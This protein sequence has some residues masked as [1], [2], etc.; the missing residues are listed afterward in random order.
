MNKLNKLY[1]AMLKSWGCTFNEDSSVQLNL[2]GVST[3]VSVDSKP[4]YLATSEN[5]N[6]ITIGKVFFH[7]AC[8]SIMSKETEIFKVI[9]KL[10]MAKIFSVF[11]P[12]CEVLF[13]IA[14][15][16]TGK[17]IPGKLLEQLEPFKGVNKNVRQE[18]ID[19]IK[20]VSIVMEDQG[21]DTRL[22]NFTL[23]KGGKNENDEPV[24][25]T[26]TPSFP[27]YTEL[28]RTAAQNEHLKPT[29]RLNFNNLNVSIQA[30]R[31]VI[32]LFEL[33]FPA[34]MDPS[35]CKY[36]VTT[37]DAA[38]LVAYLRSYGLIAADIN[39]LIGK[40]RK[41][42]DSIGLYGID[43]EWLNELDEIGE[44]KKLI[45]ALDYN[46]YNTSSST[47]E[48]RATAPIGARISS[49]N[50]L[51][52]LMGNNSGVSNGSANTAVS[53]P[54]VPDTLPGENYLGCEYS[55]INGI[56]EFKFQQSNGMIRVRRLAEDGRLINEDFQMPQI[57]QPIA[58]GYAAP[59]YGTQYI[60]Q[61]QQQPQFVLMPNGT[62][63]QV[64]QPQGSGIP[65]LG[66]GNGNNNG[67]V[68][69]PYTGQWVRANSNQVVNDPYV[70]TSTNNDWNLNSSAI[71]VN[72]QY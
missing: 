35:R 62:M 34:T 46:N 43:L 18:V 17:T 70:T 69:D 14:N 67:L 66:I 28:Y 54:K 55:Q 37:Q 8:E 24:Y 5:L 6:G 9:R 49:Y 60:T 1:E 42:F 53:A 65:M 40:F 30:V 71:G 58:N 57:Q 10:S 48:P 12:M 51:A 63:A 13:T 7:P 19:I 39:S 59:Q 4:V 61:P 64:G 25:F 29:E 23:M 56:Y 68:Q 47:S 3:P 16:K 26:A 15:K 41:E 38:R 32:A 22:I 44:I 33:V 36:S 72:S 52:D 21:I 31:I 27:F 11:Q 45:P 2:N 20:T 50:P